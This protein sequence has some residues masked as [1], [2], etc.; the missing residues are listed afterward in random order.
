MMRLQFLNL[1]PNSVRFSPV[2]RFLFWLPVCSPPQKFC[3]FPLL[4][5]PQ[6]HRLRGQ[7]V[8]VLEF[9]L[10]GQLVLMMMMLLP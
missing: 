8:V 2:S 5:R 7:S 10:L 9:L 6:P 3:L 1:V 4:L